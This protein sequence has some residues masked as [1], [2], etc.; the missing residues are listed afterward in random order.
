MRIIEKVI[1]S[2]LE[3]ARQDVIWVDTSDPSTP[4]VKTYINGKWEVTSPSGDGYVSV[5]SLTKEEYDALVEKDP[6]TLY[7]VKNSLVYDIYLGEDKIVSNDTN[8]TWSN[9]VALRNNSTLIPGMRYRII[10]YNTT[11]VQDDTQSAGH[12]FDI[13]VTADDNH[14]L[15][16]NARAARHAEDTYFTNAKLE[17]WEL[18]YCLD[19]DTAR[20]AWA[21]SESTG[22]GVIY[23]MKDEWDNKCHYDFK[24]IQ[25]KV[26]YKEQPGTV[27]NVF[28]YTFSV[29][30]GVGH[31][32]V[33]DHSLNGSY[34]Y[35]N[36]IGV[37]ES[38]SKQKLPSNVFA[39]VTTESDCYS[40]T[41]GNNC[42]SN[43]FGEGCY[44]NN[45]GNDC[46]SNLFGTNNYSNYFV[47]DCIS[48]KFGNN[49]RHNYIGI[50]CNYNTFDRD[51][52]NNTLTNNCSTNSLGEHCNHNSFGNSCSHVMIG[53]H[54]YNNTFGELVQYFITGDAEG[55]KDSWEAKS[56]IRDLIV[57]NG[58]EYVNAYCTGDTSA[59]GYCQNIKIGIG[60][61][62]TSSYDRLQINITSQIGATAS[63]TYEPTG[64]SVINV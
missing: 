12:Q 54:C 21:D 2:N 55:A 57:E 24:N 50:K 10:D 9:L 25:F 5:K 43:I 52:Q 32:T 11:T 56:Y 7:I 45:I 33:T 40:N 30:T 15:N 6:E 28:Y 20:F 37:R 18:K 42:S 39:N 59:A 13:I 46:S 29:A 60:V 61:K 23:Y 35:G 3:P 27:A 62:G 48:N 31:T 16:E 14:T 58:V 38:L 8:I 26:G 19:N 63:V 1:Q 22:K 36:K 64:S 4:V 44:N 34:C 51:C 47:S 53:N 17:A 49:C 41:I